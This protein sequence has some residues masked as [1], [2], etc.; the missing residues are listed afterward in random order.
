MPR[1]ILLA[2]I[3]AVLYLLIRRAQNAP[4]HKRRSEYIK[5][6]LGILLAVV[7][8][9]A[10]TGKMHWLGVAITGALVVLRQLGPVLL[11]FFPL[12]AS[13]FGQAAPAGGQQSTVAT[14]ILRMHLDHDSGELHGEVLRGRFEGWRLADMSREQL[15]ELM[16]YCRREDVDSEQLLANYLEQR[17]PGAQAGGGEHQAPGGSGNGNGMDRAE[18]LAVLGLDEEASDEDIVTAHRRLMQKL[19]PDRGG[20]DYLAAKINQAKDF[21]LG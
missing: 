9:L 4:P 13:R 1:L 17:F 7:V 18:A 11:R 20:N 21:L 2:A 12:L 10:L 8:L 5:L 6:A 19:H 16:A 14:E 3:A 15:E